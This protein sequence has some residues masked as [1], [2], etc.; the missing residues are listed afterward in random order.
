M[1]KA[2]RIYVDGRPV[3]LRKGKRP[4]AD[5]A[6]TRQH[7]AIY[8]R[9]RG[10]VRRALWLMEHDH[11]F[12]SLTIYGK[13]IDKVHRAFFHLFTVIEAAGGLVYNPKGKVLLIHRKGRW[14][15]PKGKLDPGESPSQAALRE[16]CEET[17]VT[18]L[19]LGKKLLETF[20]VYT[21]RGTRVL[22]RTHWYRMRS[23][24]KDV[25]RPQAEESITD[26]D[27]TGSKKLAIRLTRSYPNIHD[28]MEEAG[29]VPMDRDEDLAP[30]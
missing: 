5:A 9:R 13:D 3:F 4:D 19:E 23:A 26:A 2:L 17:G 7:P 25:L 21:E 1:P 14:D 15:L 22:K 18:D 28:V 6:W 12:A 16:V 10:D 24:G 11:L 29:L 27:W 8:Y 30:S 20:H